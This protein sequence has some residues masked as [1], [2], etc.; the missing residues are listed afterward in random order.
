MGKRFKNYAE[1]IAYNL[2]IVNE[3]GGLTNEYINYKLERQTH[4]EF[5]REKKGISVIDLHLDF[6]LQF[7]KKNVELKAQ[8]IQQNS[9][10]RRF[11]NKLLT[12]AT[13][14]RE[15]FLRNQITQNNRKK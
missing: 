14:R 3:K 6:N 9:I 2:A 12:G 13:A 1:R 4:D 11:I 10:I 15:I 8:T 7:F 5:M